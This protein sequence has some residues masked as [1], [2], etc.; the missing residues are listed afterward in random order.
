VTTVRVH[1]DVVADLRRLRKA[2]ASAADAA[3]TLVRELSSTPKRGTR[4]DRPGW[5]AYTPAPGVAVIASGVGTGTIRVLG[6]G[7]LPTLYDAERLR[8]MAES[9]TA[10]D[11]KKKS[12]LEAGVPPPAARSRIVNLAEAEGTQSYRDPGPRR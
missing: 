11:A 9:A 12:K 3:L 8:A 10:T 6:V 5:R 4:L 7:Q 2:D 1:P